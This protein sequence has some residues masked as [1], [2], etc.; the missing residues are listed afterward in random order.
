MLPKRREALKKINKM[1]KCEIK[2]EGTPDKPRLLI[3]CDGGA[4]YVRRL[5]SITHDLERDQ[6]IYR[7]DAPIGGP[8]A[9]LKE[10]V[11]ITKAATKRGG[12]TV[13]LRQRGATRR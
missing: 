9:T 10:A 11:R 1:K 5:V 7:C 3:V 4:W 6:K 2:I 13:P 12:A 8:C